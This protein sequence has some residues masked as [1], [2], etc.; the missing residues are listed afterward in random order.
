MSPFSRLIPGLA[1]VLAVVSLSACGAIGM[2]LGPPSAPPQD[3]AVT[4]FCAEFTAAGGSSH[5]VGPLDLTLPKKELSDEIRERLEQMGDL[6][7][8]PSI[9]GTW[10][11]YRSYFTAV[12]LAIADQPDDSTV[13]DYD[14]VQTGL[15]LYP[16]SRIVRN[17]YLANCV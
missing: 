6:E 10:D 8:P 9:E 5:T 17:F 15:E 14:L 7:P 11:A 12:Q 2:R 4:D 1:A 3:E 16:Q 13:E